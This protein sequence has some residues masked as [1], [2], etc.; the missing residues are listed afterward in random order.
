MSDTNKRTLTERVV[1]TI[2]IVVILGMCLFSI[3]FAMHINK[4]HF[5]YTNRTTG[6]V[7]STQSP[8]QMAEMGYE[9]NYP[10]FSNVTSW[11]ADRDAPIYLP[12]IDCC[13]RYAVYVSKEYSNY[14]RLDYEV[15]EVYGKTLTIAFS[16]YGYPDEGRGEPE[17]LDKTFVF[18]IS[19][20][21]S[22]RMPVLMEY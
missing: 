20:V 1:S 10:F 2:V 3:C 5:E 18:D 6:V 12:L 15:T 4:V 16:G 17:P 21:N 8:A 19:G 9:I 14:A 22:G 7:I 13:E 11:T